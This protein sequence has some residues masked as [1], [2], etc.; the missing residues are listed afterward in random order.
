MAQPVTLPE[1]YYL[2]NF[3]RLCEHANTL[4]SDLLSET[5]RKWL[6]RFDTLDEQAQCLLVRLLTRKG[7]WFRSDKL[8]YAEI[9]NLG[10]A[11]QLLC[12]FSFIHLNPP[13]SCQDIAK[14][15]LTKS[16]ILRLFEF[17]ASASQ[18]RKP[19]LIIE[20][21]DMRFE[22]FEQLGFQVVQLAQGEIL[23][24][25]QVLFFA[26]AYQDLSEFVLQDLGLLTFENYHLSKNTRFFR[27]RQEVT[28]LLK[29]YKLKEHYESVTKQEQVLLTSCLLAQIPPAC[30]HDYVDRKREKLINT[31]ARDLE[32][33]DKLPE[34]ISWFSKTHIPPSRERL[35]RIYEKQGQ[36]EL[37]IPIVRQMIV[38]L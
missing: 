26:N 21:T 29:I 14:N 13:I 24:T 15:L 4:Y 36:F 37:Q 34:A 30:N 25:L 35:V 12:E 17:G 19:E 32:R 6:F 7:D 2:T 3:K 18:K 23:D 10:E 1:R 11:M 16:E 8:Q 22:E 31:L 33:Q 27:A 38:S 20:L 28:N 9:P 5:E